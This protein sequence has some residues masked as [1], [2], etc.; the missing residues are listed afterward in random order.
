MQLPPLGSLRA[1]EAAA[2]HLSFT[3]A[4]AELNLTQGAISQQIKQLEGHLGFPL[5]VRGQ[6]QLRAASIAF[7]CVVFASVL[8]YAS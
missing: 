2:R 3:R 5:F 4:A 6:R 1:F 7:G 8:H